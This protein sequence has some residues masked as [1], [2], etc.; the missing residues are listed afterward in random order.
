MTEDDVNKGIASIAS[1]LPSACDTL[2]GTGLHLRFLLA[3][4]D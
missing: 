2:Q 3:D 4:H 1:K